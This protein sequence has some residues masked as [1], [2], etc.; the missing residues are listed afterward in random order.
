MSKRGHLL[1]GQS[2]NKTPPTSAYLRLPSWGLRRSHVRRSRRCRCGESRQWRSRRAGAVGAWRTGDVR[3]HAERWRRRGWRGTTRSQRRARQAAILFS[4]PARPARSLRRN[5]RG[6]R[7]RLQTE[8]G[9]VE[10]RTWLRQMS[11]CGVDGD[12]VTVRLP[13][14]FLRDWVREPL[15]RPAGAALAEG[16]P[17]SV[18]RVAIRVGG[19]G[20]RRPGSRKSVAP[21]PTE[22]ASAAGRLARPRPA[23]RGP[24]RESRPARPAL[25]LRQLRRRQA[26]RV[27]PCLRPPGGG[28]PGEPRLQPAVPLRR[29]RP[30]QDAPDARHRLGMLAARAAPGP[31]RGRPI[32]SPAC[33]PSGSCT[34]SSP[35]SVASA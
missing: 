15:R 11:L 3:R 27:R 20:A 29:R 14:R 6:V 28:Q 4:L 26:E 1:T 2:P 9:D 31:V 18:R 17:R 24:R 19:G 13:T 22:S 16:K 23:R 21:A 10:Y 12:E 35:R 33:P 34:A 7:G 32:G 30:R 8:V 25:H 5:G